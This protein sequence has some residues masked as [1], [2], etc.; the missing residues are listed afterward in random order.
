MGV[1]SSTPAAA[2]TD[3]S[4]LTK[5]AWLSIAAAIT[6][7]TLKTGAWALTGSVGLLSD[8]A[9]SAVNLVAAVIA[10]LTVLQLGKAILHFADQ[11]IHRG[12]AAGLGLC[13]LGMCLG[14]HRRCLHPQSLQMPVQ[15]TLEV[16]HHLAQSAGKGFS[17]HVLHTPSPVG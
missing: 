8:A 13:D 15:L 7:I 5:F 14:H 12:I 11:V 4:A 17:G 2:T 10:V 6:T 3:R 9:E 1:V 16:P